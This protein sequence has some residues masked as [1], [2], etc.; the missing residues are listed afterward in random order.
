MGTR[1]TQSSFT[2]GELTPRLDSRTNL[3]QY[4]IGLKTAKNA[5][6]HQEGGISNRMGLEYIGTAKYSDKDVRL[7]KFVFNSEQ[8]YI[9]EFGDKYVRFIKDG[10]YIIYPDDYGVEDG[11]ETVYEDEF[12]LGQTS[13]GMQIGGSKKTI[14]IKKD[15]LAEESEM[16]TLYSKV[17]TS[18]SNSELIGASLYTSQISGTLYG[19]IDSLDQDENVIKILKEFHSEDAE[20]IAKRGHLVEI[21]SPY[22]SEDLS[23][24]K[25]SQSGDILTLT[26]PNYES[27][28]LVRYSHYDWVFEKISFQAAISAPKNVIATFSAATPTSNTKIYSY[29]VTAVDEDTNTESERSEV[30]TVVA[31]RE[32][33][34]TNSEYITISCEEV[35]GASEYNIYRDVNGIFG[36]VGTAQPTDDGYTQYSGKFRNLTT[37]VNQYTGNTITSIKLSNGNFVY[38]NQTFAKD[39]LLYTEETIKNYYGTITALT[40]TSNSKTITIKKRGISFI[41]NNIE[42]DL[43]SSAPVIRKPF[44][45]ENYPSCSCYFQQRKIFGN[46]KDNPQTIYSSQSGT[47]NNFNVSRPLISTDA[48]TLNLD[49]REVNEI[50]HLIPM[51]DLLVLTSNSE[52]KVNGTDGIFQANPMPAAVIQSCYGASHVEP[53]ISGSMV[54]FVQSG[55]SII[56]DLGYDIMSE[57]YDGDELTIFSSHL[58]ENKEI[59]YIAYSKEPYRLIWVVF[60][61]GTC[62]S[63]TYNKKQKL[64]G[65]SRIETDGKFQ[66]VEVIREGL[67]DSAYFVIERTINNKTVKFIERTRTRFIDDTKNAFLVDCGLAATFN[68]PVTTISGLAHIEGKTVVV[69]A[70]GGIVENLVVENGQITLP[71]EATSVIVGL[72]YEFEFETLN[73]EGENTQGLKKVVNCVSAKIYKSREDFIFVGANGLGYIN[74]RSSESVF[75]AGKL[76]SKDIPFTVIS[77]AITNATIHIKQP[78]PLPLTILSVSATVD[79]QNN[80]ND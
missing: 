46:T 68:E 48:V 63:C 49:D 4:S 75:D 64:C 71:Y 9:L 44:E 32:A 27:Y 45:N 2:R 38:T 3:E 41:D 14:T 50:R 31:H 25:K 24:I 61:D 58:F 77:D 42:P 65:W 23:K 80:E 7:I 33:N 56:R 43:S 69:N 22:D 57:S 76:F 74:A 36:Y 28:N 78:L 19:Y 1:I 54:I 67:E 39:A 5:L 73:I 26:H 10:A 8:S 37:F 52:W 16:I 29:L 12:T 13:G 53:I 35:L 21:E 59:L 55:G 79:V 11:I 18:S 30:A 70:D 34:W 66:S 6:I 20:K 72:P 51:K 60:N 47:T 17:S 62:A 40:N 15:P